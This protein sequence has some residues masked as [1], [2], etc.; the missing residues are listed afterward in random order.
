MDFCSYDYAAS[1]GIDRTNGELYS[2]KYKEA[3]E[4]RRLCILVAVTS[5][6][7]CCLGA[8]QSWIGKIS[9]SICGAQH[10]GASQSS[11]AKPSDADCTVAC[12]KKGAK[13]VFVIRDK[14]YQIEN[15]DLAGLPDHAGQSVRVTGEMTGETIKISQISPYTKQHK[16]EKSSL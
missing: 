10:K 7:V 14:V 12:V 13:Y 4:L 16:G 3:S 15:Q 11:S 6:S 5:L 8:E 2:V 1:L 9:D